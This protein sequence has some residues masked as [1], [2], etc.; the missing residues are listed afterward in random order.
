MTS[1]M[2]E[3]SST[4]K[5]SIDLAHLFHE[6][7][8]NEWV[9]RVML[10]CT[11]NLNRIMLEVFRLFWFKFIPDYIFLFGEDFLRRGTQTFGCLICWK[12]G[13]FLNSSYVGYSNANHS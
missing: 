1:K 9:R 6:N 13:T 8:D 7:N 12:K 10:L 2:I 11:T 3:I 5:E 4:S